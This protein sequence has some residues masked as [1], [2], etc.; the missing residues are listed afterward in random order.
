MIPTVQRKKKERVVALRN[1]LRNRG[2]RGT[3]RIVSNRTCVFANLNILQHDFLR[4]D[5][6]TRFTSVRF[7][8]ALVLC[9]VLHDPLDTYE[10]RQ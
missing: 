7:V 1:N 5:R 10:I 3:R 4:L 8:P 6:F 9:H 2:A